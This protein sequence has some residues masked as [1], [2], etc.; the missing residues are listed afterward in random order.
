MKYVYLIKS[1]FSLE[2]DL[3]KDLLLKTN[4]NKE[5]VKNILD[6][7]PENKRTRN[8][9][10]WL[11]KLNPSNWTEA[12]EIIE[13][14]FELVIKKQISSDINEFNSIDELR[15]KIEE[16]EK[17]KN[18]DLTS[19]IP[20]GAN[21][22]FQYKNYIV[23]ELETFEATKQ[24]CNTSK[25]SFSSPWCIARSE[26]SFQQYNPPY[27][28]VL[29]NYKPYAVITENEI[30]NLKNNIDYNTTKELGNIVM[31][32]RDKGYYVASDLIDYNG[33]ILDEVDFEN[34]LENI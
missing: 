4:N 22:L 5:L 18:N 23:I 32:L 9:A 25:N 1:S 34:I 14:Y 12:K 24:L 10:F 28:L 31:M 19:N 6:C 20:E 7:L 15:N 29:K 11:L 8:F 27:Y 33:T 21:F 26:D 16:I 2:A 17:S 3:E 30:W 13:K